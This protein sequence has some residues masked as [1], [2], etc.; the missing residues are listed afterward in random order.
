VLAAA[1]AGGGGGG[2]AGAGLRVRLGVDDV[3]A[4]TDL[5]PTLRVRNLR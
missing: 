2:D 5:V 4:V 3:H 1:G